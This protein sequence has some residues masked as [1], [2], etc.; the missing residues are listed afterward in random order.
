MGKCPPEISAA[1]AKSTLL[2]ISCSNT[3]SIDLYQ[4]PRLQSECGWARYNIAWH[5]ILFGVP[6]IVRNCCQPRKTSRLWTHLHHLNNACSVSKFCGWRQAAN[7][8][9]FWFDEF[10]DRAERERERETQQRLRS[11]VMQ[12]LQRVKQH[13]IQIAKGIVLTLTFS[14][15]L[16]VGL[17]NGKERRQRLNNNYWDLSCS[18]TSSTGSEPRISQFLPKGSKRQQ[19]LS[20]LDRKLPFLFIAA[21]QRYRYREWVALCFTITACFQTTGAKWVMYFFLTELQVLTERLTNFIWSI[22]PHSN[23]RYTDNTESTSTEH[24][25]LKYSYICIPSDAGSCHED[26]PGFNPFYSHQ[27]WRVSMFQGTFIPGEINIKVVW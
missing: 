2:G 18:N 9:D 8:T 6:A 3:F 4:H 10:V 1:S 22:K 13:L 21:L 23:N 26:L 7:Q 15:E 5:K 17:S 16:R 25:N 27:P 14:C 24:I 12:E 20:R 19:C 11:D